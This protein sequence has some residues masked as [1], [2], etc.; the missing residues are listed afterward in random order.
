MNFKGDDCKEFWMVGESFYIS[1]ELRY[2]RERSSH[3]TETRSL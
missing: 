3:L 1:G 2:N